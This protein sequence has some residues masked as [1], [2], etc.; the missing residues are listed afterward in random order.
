MAFGNFRGG[1]IEGEE[2][3]RECLQ[4]EFEEEVGLIIRVEEDLPVIVHRYDH[5]LVCLHPFFCSR[6]HGE[7]R[8]IQVAEHRWVTVDE[9]PAIRFP[10]A[11]DR[12]IAQVAEAF[13]RRN[14]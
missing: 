8:D 9:L 2:S 4:R 11:N 1:K 5:G 13:L 10:P 3:A 7:P 12:L 14:R 6:I